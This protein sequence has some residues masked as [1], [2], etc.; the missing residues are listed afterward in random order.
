[1]SASVADGRGSERAS[2]VE[3]ENYADGGRGGG[4][5]GGG[6]V[7]G[8]GRGRSDGGGGVGVGGGGGDGDGD[9]DG[10]GA[11]SGGD[12]GGSGGG[13]TGLGI[14]GRESGVR[15]RKGWSG[16]RVRCTRGYQEHLERRL[17]LTQV[18]LLGLCRETLP[19]SVT[20]S[21]FCVGPRAAL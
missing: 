16:S 21:M 17:E 2:A 9:G 1:M 7:D 5:G 15:G 4:V 3:D 20:I 14:E 13:E 8:Y 19:V 6:G 12:S 10:D 18:C 11:N